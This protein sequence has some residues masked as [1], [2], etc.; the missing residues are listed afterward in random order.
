MAAM[1]AMVMQK[2][3]RPDVRLIRRLL[4]EMMGLI[5]RHNWCIPGEVEVE[6][7]LMT[8]LKGTKNEDGSITQD[9]LSA[10]AV[11]PFV[12]F[13]LARNPQ[14]KRAEGFIKQIKYSYQKHREG[15]QFRP[16]LK[17][18]ANRMNEDSASSKATFTFEEIQASMIFLTC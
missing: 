12:T 13:C 10:G 2:A 9:V 7:A 11:F 8:S 1:V 16:F 17:L 18:E 4:A 15:F 5:I 14:E 6:R 3:P